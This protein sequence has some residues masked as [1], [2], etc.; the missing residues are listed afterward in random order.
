MKRVWLPT[1][2]S[3]IATFA[4]GPLLTLGTIERHD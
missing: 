1:I 3:V 2:G 4:A